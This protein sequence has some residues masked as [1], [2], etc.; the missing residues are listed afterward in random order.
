MYFQ[1]ASLYANEKKMFWKINILW[2]TQ[3]ILKSV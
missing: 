1:N 2:N 3:K